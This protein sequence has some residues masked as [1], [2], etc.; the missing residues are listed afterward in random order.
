VTQEK[1]IDRDQVEAIIG[2][3]RELV[4]WTKLANR[5]Q[6]AERFTEILDSDKK[7]LVY[8][9]SDGERGVRE[10]SRL[11]RVSKDLI[12]AWWRDWDELGIME[13][14]GGVR[15]RRQRMVSLRAVGIEVPPLP[16]KEE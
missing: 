8:E 15:G 13:Q 10:L 16:G 6:V 11:A 5:P 3:L 1:P 7:K 2:L 9:Y 14:S 4:A 12:R